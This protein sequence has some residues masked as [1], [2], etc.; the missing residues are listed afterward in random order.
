MYEII[1]KQNLL[2]GF[3]LDLRI[4]CT[5]KV[6]LATLVFFFVVANIDIFSFM[7]VYVLLLYWLQICSIKCMCVLYF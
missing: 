7:V 1:A 4:V 6:K 5:N 2:S 3:G